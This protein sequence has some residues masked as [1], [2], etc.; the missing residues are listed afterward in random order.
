[1]ISLLPYLQLILTFG[2]ICILLYAFRNFLKS[3]QNALEEKLNSILKRMDVYDM[4]LKEVED[5][6]KLG[7]DRFRGQ[8]DLNEAFI[9]CMLAFIDFERA[10]CQH[11]G[12]KDVEDLERA[13]ETLQ[14]FLAKK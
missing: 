3:P 13:R 6:L 14:K 11:T 8:N 2:N 10:F 9:Y 12:Y 1:M 4:K 5:S 7:N